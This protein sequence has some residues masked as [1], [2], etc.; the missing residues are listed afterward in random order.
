[1]RATIALTALLGEASESALSQHQGV[2]GWVE[3]AHRGMPSVRSR[4]ADAP[5][6]STRLWVAGVAS[7]FGLL[8]RW[9]M[10][11]PWEQNAG[12]QCDCI[13]LCR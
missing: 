2:V 7:K 13:D 3:N 4:R 5:A 9:A 1:M 12:E 6:M 8:V 10:A 11:V